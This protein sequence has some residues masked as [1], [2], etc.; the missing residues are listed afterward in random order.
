MI[1]YFGVSMFH[2]WTFIDP[3]IELWVV[4]YLFDIWDVPDFL[5]WNARS[6][7]L[8]QTLLLGSENLCQYEIVFRNGYLGKSRIFNLRFRIVESWLAILLEQKLE[9]GERISRFGIA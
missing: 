6:E 4:S 1:S 5:G 3:P 9:L 7:I 2:E 8:V